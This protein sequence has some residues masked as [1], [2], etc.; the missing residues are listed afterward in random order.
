MPQAVFYFSRRGVI[1]SNQSAMLAV[2]QLVAVLL[3]LTVWSI[4]VEATR[5]TDAPARGLVVAGTVGAAVC[6]GVVRGA[7][8]ATSSTWTFAL[9]SAAPPALVLAIVSLSLVGPRSWLTQAAFVASI[10]LL[11][12]SLSA[13]AGLRLLW[14]AREQEPTRISLPTLAMLFKYGTATWLAIGLQTGTALLILHWVAAG[15]S[16]H[17]AAGTLAAGFALV[18]VAVT[19]VNLIAPILF[20]QWTTDVAKSVRRA[21]IEASTFV[22]FVAIAFP[23]VVFSLGA[24]LVT[25]LFGPEYLPHLWMFALVSL[26]AGPQCFAKIGGVLYSATGRPMLAA[27]VDGT[28]LAVVAVGISLVDRN[29]T[30]AAMVWVIAEYV[31][32]LLGL[33]VAVQ[34]SRRLSSVTSEPNH[35]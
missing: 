27:G 25:L 10:F 29:V 23:L 33:C 17:A 2:F 18:A 21:F 15:G 13:G 8:L 6:Y 9:F 28:R 24:P 22:L 3:L 4:L 34:V 14:E 11:A 19:P 12:Y 30:N 35:L 32:L 7:L 1:S 26:T 5:G 20:K 31:A 16:N